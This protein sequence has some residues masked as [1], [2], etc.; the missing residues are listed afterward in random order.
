M[1]ELYEALIRCIGQEQK[2]F[3]ALLALARLQQRA[4]VENDLRRIEKSTRAMHVALG[5]LKRT[6]ED[7]EGLVRSLGEALGVRTNRPSLQ[8]LLGRLQDPFKRRLQEALR[9][10]LRTG[11]LLYRSNQQTIHLIRLSMSLL[12]EEARMWADLLTGAEGYDERGGR[13][14]ASGK[15]RLLEGKA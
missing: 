11:H 14:P 12:D 3:Q 2:L 1:K 6:Q 4:V 5:R 10:L 7:R 13:S 8:A 9:T 15:P